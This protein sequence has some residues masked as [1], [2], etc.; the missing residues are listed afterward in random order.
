[1][2]NSKEAPKTW[3]KSSAVLSEPIVCSV[4]RTDSGMMQ[5]YNFKRSGTLNDWRGNMIN[6]ISDDR[7]VDL[8]LDRMLNK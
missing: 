3:L 8:V 2:P 1:M 4:S 6:G 7:K 5:A